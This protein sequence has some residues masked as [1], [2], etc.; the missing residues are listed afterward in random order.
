MAISFYSPKSGNIVNTAN[1]R[2][3]FPGMAHTGAARAGE[4]LT[5]PWDRMGQFW[6]PCEL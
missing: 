4:N 6:Y 5:K 3:G 1:V 2:N